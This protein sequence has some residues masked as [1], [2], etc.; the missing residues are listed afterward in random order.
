MDASG[1]L[2]NCLG[3][4][5]LI[6]GESSALSGSRG[7]TSVVARGGTGPDDLFSIPFEVDVK[8]RRKRR[9]VLGES[10]SFEQEILKEA[11]LS[12]IQP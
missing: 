8:D 6:L 5:G 3:V 9:L 1:I 12:N 7:F 4:L 11:T 10:I 2:R